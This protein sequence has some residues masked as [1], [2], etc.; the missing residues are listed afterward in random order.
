MQP[1]SEQLARS[2]CS[3]DPTSAGNLPHA[4]ILPA[5][6]VQ[7]TGHRDAITVMCAF[8]C[9]FCSDSQNALLLVV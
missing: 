8:G 7:Y 9:T 4:S 1:H 3:E 2:S 5:G 6:R